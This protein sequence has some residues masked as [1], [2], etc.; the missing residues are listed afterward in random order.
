[1]KAWE[2]LKE[3]LLMVCDDI[4]QS[5]SNVSYQDVV[6][7][8]RCKLIKQKAEVLKKEALIKQQAASYMK[9]MDR[10][11]HKEAPTDP[12]SQILISKIHS[13]QARQAELHQQSEDLLTASR[14]LDG[15]KVKVCGHAGQ[16]PAGLIQDWMRDSNNRK[17]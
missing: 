2:L 12:L 6:S 10:I 5:T 8:T 4:I 3:A 14:A 15:Y 9:I 17:S 1:M 13:L 16:D 7:W 11:E